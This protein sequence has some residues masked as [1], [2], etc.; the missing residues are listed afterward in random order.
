[1][2]SLDWFLEK[3]LLK[4]KDVQPD[5]KAIALLEQEQKWLSQCFEKAAEDKRVPTSRVQ[6]ALDNFTQVF[7]I[8]VRN[9][10]P[11]CPKAYL[12]STL[13]EAL[14][15]AS[16]DALQRRQQLLFHR[17]LRDVMLPFYEEHQKIGYLRSSHGT[18]GASAKFKV[19]T[20]GGA[21]GILQQTLDAG[22]Q[23]LMG[24]S[25]APSA[26]RTLRARHDGRT[27]TG[28]G[29]VSKAGFVREAATMRTDQL[30]NDVITPII[31][32]GS[33]DVQGV[34]MRWDGD[35]GYASGTFDP[36]RKSGSH[37]LGNDLRAEEPQGTLLKD[38]VIPEIAYNSVLPL[39]EKLRNMKEELIN[40]PIN[41]MLKQLYEIFEKSMQT[42]I[43]LAEKSGVAEEGA[44]ASLPQ[45][46]R[47]GSATHPETKR[48]EGLKHTLLVSLDAWRTTEI[49]ALSNF[50]SEKLGKMPE[51][52][53]SSMKKVFTRTMPD[54]F[55][56][57][58][59]KH[60]KRTLGT[61]APTLAKDVAE[62]TLQLVLN[63]I[64]NII[65]VRLRKSFESVVKRTHGLM[66]AAI[67][68]DTSELE[69]SGAFQISQHYARFTAGLIAAVDRSSL[70]EDLLKDYK[71][72]ADILLL[73]KQPTL[74]IAA[75]Q[76]LEALFP[77]SDDNSLDDATPDDSTEAEGGVEAAE[78]E[79]FKCPW[80][81]CTEADEAGNLPLQTLT[82]QCR[83][84]PGNCWCEA[85][86]LDTIYCRRCVKYYKDKAA[87]QRECIK[88][89]PKWE[90]LRVSRKRKRPST[91]A[92]MMSPPEAPRQVRPRTSG[93]VEM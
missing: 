45:P 14:V 32:S 52:H 8:D 66:Q 47:A 48:M 81:A 35:K 17:L 23:A 88:R 36:Y 13:A 58:G 74:T 56:V 83:F 34:E 20:L 28:K 59:N 30:R 25:T 46:Q 86:D 3:Q 26:A 53:M 70:A 24:F 10:I 51:M 90:L 4:K 31:K 78:A 80:C 77:T 11:D 57:K 67:T 40:A 76:G 71:H 16:R 60:R 15:K 12:M 29:G 49:D 64:L 84:K 2:T 9:K 75:D 22:D 27:V 38:L 61:K 93:T 43:M 72:K 1:M 63:Q 19:P 85:E 41:A 37:Q 79:G 92:G 33:S 44:G 21:D 87:K 69:R 73:A 42:N 65:N 18:A 68:G 6:P 91:T 55:K 5:K 89:E 7:T 39:Q 82:G 50:F 54:V 62:G